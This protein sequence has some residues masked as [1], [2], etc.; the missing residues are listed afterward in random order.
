MVQ[1]DLPK[2]AGKQ[3]EETK[4]PILLRIGSFFFILL[5]QMEKDIINDTFPGVL[6]NG[7]LPAI[8]S[9]SLII[10]ITDTH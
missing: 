5:S 2:K 1:K 10:L 4:E 7:K 3:N 9:H 6:I 8:F